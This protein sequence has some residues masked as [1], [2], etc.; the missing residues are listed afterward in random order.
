MGKKN[1]SKSNVKRKRKMVAAVRSSPVAAKKK[2]KSDDGVMQVDPNLMFQQMFAS[3]AKTNPAL[4][5]SL[6]HAHKTPPSNQEV[7]QED[8]D[9]DN[10]NEED[11]EEFDVS[12]ANDP[13]NPANWGRQFEWL[14]WMSTSENKLYNSKLNSVRNGTIREAIS[15]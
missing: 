3:W 7:D 10:G 5:A 1:S 15:K 13:A 14:T 8:V 6:M 12:A 4:V 2:Q 11:D 9:E